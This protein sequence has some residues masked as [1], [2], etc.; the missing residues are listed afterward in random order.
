MGLYSLL[1]LVSCALRLSNYTTNNKKQLFFA[2]SRTQH[3]HIGVVGLVAG[4]NSNITLMDTKKSC[5]LISGV[6]SLTIYTHA[7]ARRHVA[8]A[9]APTT[10]QLG[11]TPNMVIT[12]NTH[13][14]PFQFINILCV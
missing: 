6:R 9:V 11:S 5:D 3:R 12:L 2:D 4:V 13:T 10:A 8:L 14:R 7:A 1:M